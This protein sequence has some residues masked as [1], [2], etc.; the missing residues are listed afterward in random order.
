MVRDCAD[1]GVRRDGRDRVRCPRPCGAQGDRP[2]AGEEFDCTR[3]HEP[4]P[5]A[6]PIVVNTDG[7]QAEITPGAMAKWAADVSHGQEAAVVAKCWTIAPQYI[8][9]RYFAEPAT[10]AT[11]FAQRPVSGQAG[12]AW[13]RYES[14]Y[15][16]VPWSEA[17]SGYPCPR[18]RL[19]AAQQIYPDDFV[20]HIARRF[21]LRAQGRP[22][23][24]A[25]TAASYP[26]ECT[27]VRGPIANVERGDVQLI[28]VTREDLPH[29]DIRWIVQAGLLT[30]RMAL[31]PGV[32]CVQA[33]A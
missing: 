2:T 28:T 19:N 21:I 33:A 5:A 24:P 29:G 30:M 8:A 23:N 6:A 25:D 3:H 22:I 20:A 4:R 16:H 14:A 11:I 18:I 9:E 32:V 1:G 17:K 12:V 10:V 7:L 26:L 13:G 27:V 15:A 31:E